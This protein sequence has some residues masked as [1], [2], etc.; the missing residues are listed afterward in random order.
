MGG[1]TLVFTKMVH[2]YFVWRIFSRDLIVSC[3]SI[4]DNLIQAFAG[5]RGVLLT[6]LYAPT[7]MSTHNTNGF[8]GEGRGLFCR[9]HIGC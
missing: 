2:A 1:K 5:V 7:G 9:Y 8:R 4:S 6:L 3:H